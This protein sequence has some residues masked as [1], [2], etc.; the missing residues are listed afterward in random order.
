MGPW[1]ALSGVI[2][3]VLHRRDQPHDDFPFFRTYTLVCLLA[4]SACGGA[5]SS[6]TPSIPWAPARS[7]HSARHA[8][9]DARR[10]DRPGGAG[11]G[12]PR[13]NALAARGRRY[14]Q[15][16]ATAPETLPAHS[17]MMTGLYPAGTACTRTR[18]SWPT[19]H[20]V[21]A[22]RS[23]GRWLPHARPSSRRSSW[24]AG[25]DSHAASTSTMT[26]CQPDRL[27]AHRARRPI[28]A[29]VP[30]PGVLAAA[31]SL[32][33]LLRSAYALRAPPRLS[34]RRTRRRHTSARSRRWM[35]SSAASS[36]RSTPSPLVKARLPR[37]VVTSDHGEGLGDHGELQ[38]GNLLYQSTMHVPLVVVGPGTAAAVDDEP[39]STRRVFHTI[40]EW[41]GLVPP[42]S[43]A[44]A[45][46]AAQA[47]LAAALAGRTCRAEALAKA[48][49]SFSERR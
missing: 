6:G 43:P 8:R 35:S 9:H 39:V 21:V 22:A 11:C 1:S 12:N 28:G 27:N 46:P 5:T 24:R 7:V 47:C 45:W 48:E 33:A 19:A 2:V 17:S 18:G 40:L 41:A 26:R 44:T 32:G 38:H 3:R 14:R 23:E 30:R 34:P 42:T 15:A 25:S 37:I 20:P 49:K 10:R 29:R 36:R 13:F 31:L 4:V 16:Y